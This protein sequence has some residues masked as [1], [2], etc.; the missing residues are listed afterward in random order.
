MADK[1]IFETE[2]EVLVY[3]LTDEDGVES[4]FELL[5]IIPP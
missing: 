2:E 4:D 1:E 3:T 5:D